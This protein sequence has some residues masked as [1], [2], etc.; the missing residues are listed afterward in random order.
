MMKCKNTLT[1]VN[2]SR[3]SWPSTLWPQIQTDFQFCVFYKSI[4]LWPS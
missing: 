4:K 2:S 1:K 3:T